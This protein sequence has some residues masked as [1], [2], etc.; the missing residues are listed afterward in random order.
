MTDQPNPREQLE[1]AVPAALRFSATMMREARSERDRQ[2]AALSLLRF[3]RHPEAKPHVGEA[4]TV[5][6]IDE[7]RLLAAVANSS[8]DELRALVDEL[9][10][11]EVHALNVIL[12]RREERASLDD[13]D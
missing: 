5:L 1:A 4:L 6:G 12:D 3:H 2:R 10:E 7:D 8:P 13:Q 9:N 11:A